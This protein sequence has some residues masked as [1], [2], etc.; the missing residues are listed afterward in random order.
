M[1]EAKKD[2]SDLSALLCINGA[3]REELMGLYCLEADRPILNGKVIAGIKP[4]S[5]Q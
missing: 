1:S 4:K 5:E 3:K 2:E